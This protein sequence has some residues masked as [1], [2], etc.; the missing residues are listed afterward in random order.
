MVHASLSS[1]TTGGVHA[2]TA[3]ASVVGAG[4]EVVADH[5]GIDTGAIDT[6]VVGAGIEV[7]TDDR[8]VETGSGDAGV[9]RAVVAVRAVNGDGRA[10]AVQT[11]MECAG[12]VVAARRTV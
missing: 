5:R 11:L 9:D 6:G 8:L 1:Q 3:D 4:V 7:I 2:L 12:I 10:D